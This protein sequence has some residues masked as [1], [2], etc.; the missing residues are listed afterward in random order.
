[1]KDVIHSMNW[2]NLTNSCDIYVKMRKKSKQK[3]KQKT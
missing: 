3:K 1:M 2:S